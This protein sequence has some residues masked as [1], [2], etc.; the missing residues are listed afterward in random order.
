MNA[1]STLARPTEPPFMLPTA[2]Q[3]P[4]TEARRLAADW[5]RGAAFVETDLPAYLQDAYQLDIT[6]QYAEHPT[7]SPIGKASGQL[8]LNLR[9]VEAD[10]AAGLGFVVLKTVIAQDE[11]GQQAM[12][13]WAT[14]ETHMTV[15]PIAG[16]RIARLGWTVTW[17]GRG[18]S[19]S[20][21]AYLRLLQA[22]VQVG[23]STGMVVAPSCKYHLPGPGEAGYREGEY[24]HTTRELAASWHAAGAAGPLIVEKDFSPTLAGSDLAS[25]QAQTLDWLRVV[26]RLVKEALP[27]PADVS[28]G[29]KVMNTLFDDEFQVAMLRELAVAAPPHR[30]DYITYANRLFDPRRR[31]GDTVGAAYGGPDLSHRNLTVLDAARRQAR[32]EGWL[33]ALPELSGTGDVSSGRIAVEYGLRGATSVQCH[34]LFQLPDAYYGSPAAG[35]Q[36]SKSAKALHL[37]YFHPVEGLVPWLLHLRHHE[38]MRTSEGLTRWR[39]LATVGASAESPAGVR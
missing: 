23:R 19:E 36:A 11:G 30:A 22:A 24:R 17:K 39:D 26:P 33:D 9:Q 8:S 21:A 5:Q 25:Q 20:I 27:D 10:A 1:T 29:M 3:L 7:R 13:A 15:E 34:T 32:A 35:Q 37:L 18:W 14:P 12:A 2:P 28:V 38:G 6:G 16:R 4:P 31:A